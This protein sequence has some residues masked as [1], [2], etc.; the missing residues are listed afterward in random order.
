MG[1]TRAMLFSLSSL[2][3]MKFPVSF[4]LHHFS[5][6]TFREYL[7]L[8]SLFLSSPDSTNTKF[9][10]AFAALNLLYHLNKYIL[11][12]F[13]KVHLALGKFPQ[14]LSPLTSYSSFSCFFSVSFNMSPQY[15]YSLKHY[16]ELHL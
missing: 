14:A 8:Q 4:L 3:L 7:Q 1:C 11:C 2:S 9:S 6:C 12:T 5:I 10:I 15:C 16:P 13:F